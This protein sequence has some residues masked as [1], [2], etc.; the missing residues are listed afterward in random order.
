MFKKLLLLT[1]MFS[2][3]ACS[4]QDDTA[5]N[6]VPA[7]SAVAEKYVEGRHYT[8]IPAPIPVS[9][10]KI[11]VTEFFWYGCP[12]CE[13]F[14]PL[15]EAWDKKKPADVALVR[16]PAVWRD[17]MKLH[18]KV[19]FLVQGLPNRDFV[20]AALFAPIIALRAEESAEV[21]NRAIAG[22]L[23]KFGVSEADYNARIQAPEIEAQMLAAVELMQKAGVGGTP[24]IMVNGKYL[25]NNEAAGSMEEIL[26]IADFLIEKERP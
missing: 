15:L 22:F 24:A 11:T 7:Q 1:L 25:V 20:H 23:S 21:Q 12:H 26:E 17:I 9:G 2:L 13:H 14:E 8:V 18:A 16:S 6:S 19:F 3:F 4:G 5:T 10:D